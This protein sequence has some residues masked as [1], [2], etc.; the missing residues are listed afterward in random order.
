MSRAPS[1][2]PTATVMAQPG[3]ECSRK[4]QNMVQVSERYRPRKGWNDIRVSRPNVLIEDQ[5]D[6]PKARIF[7]LNRMLRVAQIGT[8][9]DVLVDEAACGMKH[10][11]RKVREDFLGS[12]HFPPCACGSEIPFRLR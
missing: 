3:N 4:A 12:S 8:L 7:F 11:V 2:G 10:A 1:L 6:C 9:A 5:G